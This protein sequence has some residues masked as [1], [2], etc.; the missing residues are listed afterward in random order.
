MTLKN[1]AAE[2]GVSPS[3]ISRVLHGYNKNF[4][5][6]PEV[7]E[8][9]LEKVRESGYRA[10]PVFSSIRSCRNRQIAFL[11]AGS[12]FANQG[13][14]LSTAIDV[15][16]KE[17]ARLQY[18][19]NYSFSLDVPNRGYELPLWRAAGMI[20]PHVT[21][22]EELAAI[23]QSGI[24]Y[25]VFNGVAGNLGCAVMSDEPYNT[26][27]LLDRLTSLGHRRI[28]Y[29]N[30][31]PIPAAHYSLAERRNTFFA[32]CREKGLPELPEQCNYTPEG[33]E[34]TIHAIETLHPTAVICYE[35]GSAQKILHAAWEHGI[36]I[37]EQLSVAAFNDEAMLNFTIPPLTRIRIPAVEMGV[38]TVRQLMLRIEKKSVPDN[39]IPRIRGTLVEGG[40]IA[41]PPGN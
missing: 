3:T 30:F 7:R 36:R 35:S 33:Q 40:S 12:K 24:P 5:V 20:V 13:S 6:A 15:M 9:I 37:P 41:P 25:A 26:R 27:L 4:S 39:L 17:L 28:L 2:L 8:R 34:A 31:P 1:I 11:F 22:P 18:E 16:A 10:N 23:E 38:E 29:V 32:Y 14:V 19:F 21:A